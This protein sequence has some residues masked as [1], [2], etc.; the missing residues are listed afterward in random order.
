MGGGDAVT[1]AMA[2]Q[3]RQEGGRTSVAVKFAEEREEFPEGNKDGL[4]VPWSLESQ[5]HV[6]HMLTQQRNKMRISD[7]RA[8]N[9]P[10][11]SNLSVGTPSKR[12]AY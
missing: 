8:A 1:R 6:N 4:R 7:L 3:R 11:H 5:Y 2:L 12:R 10:R 9:A